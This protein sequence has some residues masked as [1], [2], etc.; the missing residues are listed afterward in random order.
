VYA[1]W[2]ECNGQDEF[3]MEVSLNRGFNVRT[4]ANITEIISS[5]TSALIYVSSSL[6]LGSTTPLTLVPNGS[7]TQSTISS[8]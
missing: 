8:S 1:L 2:W 5:M 6:V 4:T 3:S 7:A